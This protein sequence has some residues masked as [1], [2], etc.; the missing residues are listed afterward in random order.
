MLLSYHSIFNCTLFIAN[1]KSPSTILHPVTHTASLIHS[2][3]YQGKMPLTCF[4]LLWCNILN[5]HIYKHIMI[6][7]IYKISLYIIL[8]L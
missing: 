6:V 1:H 5:H 2:I 3:F 7:S 8:R 4:Y